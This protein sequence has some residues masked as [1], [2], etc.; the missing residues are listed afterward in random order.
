M[1][2]VVWAPLASGL[3]GPVRVLAEEADPGT[4]Q[5]EYLAGLRA[6]AGAADRARWDEALPPERAAWPGRGS[7]WPCI[8]SPASTAGRAE[9]LKDE[10]QLLAQPGA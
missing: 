10:F 8:A 7:A 1:A 6:I 3:L 9:R 2:A 5:V 4:T